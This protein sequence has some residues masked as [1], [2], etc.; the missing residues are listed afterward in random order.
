MRSKLLVASLACLTCVLSSQIGFLQET[1]VKPGQEAAATAAA[2]AQ[3][4]ANTGFLIGAPF[5][6]GNLTVFPVLSKTPRNEDRFI[7]LEEGLK[8]R[9]VEVRE[10]GAHVDRPLSRAA[11]GRLV[12]QR[13]NSQRRQRNARSPNLSPDA[14]TGEGDSDSANAGPLSQR[15]EVNRLIVVNRSDKPLYLMPGEVIVGGSQDRTIGEEM[16]IAPTGKPVAVAVFCVEHDRWRPRDA[17]QSARTLRAL[18]RGQAAGEAQIPLDEGVFHKFVATPGS[19]NKAGRQAVQSGDG[20][21]AVWD[22][23]RT[24]NK[25]LGAETGSA[26]FTAN[27]V[28][29]KTQRKSQAYLNDLADHVSREDRVVGVVVAINGKIDSADVFE[30][31]PLFR[32]LWPKLLKG[33]VLDA[34]SAA[35]AKP[36]ANTCKVADAATF[37]ATIL[38]G[39]VSGTKQTKGG[40]VV[41]HRE[42]QAG[43]SYSASSGKMQGGM[44]GAIHAAGYAP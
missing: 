36:P 43:V 21:Q 5:R 11:N 9:T 18:N 23:V 27:Y 31:T 32:K 16:A 14:Q 19:L 29:E 10:M 22:E 20:Q 1:G 30:S 28:N 38:Q 3:P 15:N 17:E 8:A 37:L 40:L 42:T 24:A 34:L 7:T 35:D 13:A 6:H 2:G 12:V 4:A 33:Y 39:A 25:K 44:G 41:T 26:A